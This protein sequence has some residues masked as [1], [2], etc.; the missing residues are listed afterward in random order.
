MKEAFRIF[1]EDRGITECKYLDGSLDAQVALVAAFEKSVEDNS[2]SH[3]QYNS[4]DLVSDRSL[5]VS[6]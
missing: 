3:I 4:F 2:L 1:L 6:L 5:L